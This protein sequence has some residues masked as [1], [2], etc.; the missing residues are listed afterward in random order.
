[1]SSPSNIDR[2]QTYSSKEEYV[3]S[4]I[5]WTASEQIAG[6]VFDLPLHVDI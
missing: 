5:F 3:L 2:V 6:R 1:M 4:V